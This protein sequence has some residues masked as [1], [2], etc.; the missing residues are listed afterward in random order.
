MVD[1]K[2]KPKLSDQYCYNKRCDEVEKEK[3]KKP[4][5]KRNRCGT[6]PGCKMTDVSCK[7]KK[8]HHLRWCHKWDWMDMMSISGWFEQEGTNTVL[9]KKK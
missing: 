4:K 3:E 6:C 9:T 2:H 8:E 1:Q 7:L 5:M